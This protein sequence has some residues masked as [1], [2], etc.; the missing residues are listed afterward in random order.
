[1]LNQWVRANSWDSITRT[2]LPVRVNA[3]PIGG[4]DGINGGTARPG[5]TFQPSAGPGGGV[6]SNAEMGAGGANGGGA[7]GGGAG[8][9][10]GGG[11]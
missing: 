8:G 9:G 11:G 10:G 7:G 2:N 6:G 3:S 5:N 4:P 1:V